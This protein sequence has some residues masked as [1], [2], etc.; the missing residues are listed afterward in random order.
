MRDHN[1]QENYD[2]SQGMRGPVVKTNKE[3]VTIRLDADTLDWFRQQCSNGGSYQAMINDA[4]RQHISQQGEPLESLLRRVIKE[5][6]AW[7]KWGQASGLTPKALNNRLFGND[8][9][10][11]V[12]I[13]VLAWDKVHTTKAY[14]N[15]YFTS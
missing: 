4:L 3:R 2:F 15:V 1:M 8:D 10:V 9:A 7:D 13:Q 6:M 5:E 12:R 14:G 11:T